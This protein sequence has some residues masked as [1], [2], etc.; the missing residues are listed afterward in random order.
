MLKTQHSTE[1]ER[2]AV[3]LFVVVFATLLMIVITISFVQLMIKDQQQA[4]A[5]DL[6]QSAYDSAKSG[7]EDAK[8]LLLLEQAC[9]NGTAPPAVN[10]TAVTN[11]INAGECNTIPA[12]FGNQS[13]PNKSD[14][15]T[16]IQQEEGDTA[17]QQA[18]T[19]VKI[20][21]NTIDY[22]AVL[23]LNQSNIVPLKG[24]SQFDSVRISWFTHDDVAVSGAGQAITFPSSGPNVSLPQ[25][26]EWDVNMPSLLRAQLMQFGPNFKLSDFD[27][28]Q[29]GNKSNAN[30]LF[31]YPSA[32]GV[33]TLSFGL[34]T[35]RRSASSVPQQ[36]RCNSSFVDGEYA[37]SVTLTLPE[38]M[39]G[40][41]A[42][43]TAFLNLSA[44]YNG[45]NY[46]VELLNAGTIVEF[47]HVQ[48]KVDSTGRANNMF[49]RVESRIEFKTDFAYPLAAVDIEGD[50]CK[51]FV[52]TDKDPGPTD[53][54]GYPT[55]TCKP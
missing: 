52:I 20:V 51:N 23:D 6:S 27:D 35:P 5:S 36:V 45:A 4:T 43:R 40:N 9:G 14:S 8:R 34:D 16:M 1:R 26:P 37:C 49:R 33:D 28:S 31:L 48:P 22:K 39:T 12:Y 29:P 19:C 7:V 3:A 30:T 18:Y 13:D 2:G 44:L 53:S 11:A 15:E 47:D 24:V 42:Q 41:A 50:L 32:T 17:L 46:K 10:C 38:P 21:P 25:T 54:F 55:A